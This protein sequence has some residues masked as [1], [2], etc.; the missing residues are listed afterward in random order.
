MIRIKTNAGIAQKFNIPPDEENDFAADVLLTRRQTNKIKNNPEIYRFL[1]TNLVFDFLPKGSKDTYL[2]K[3]RIIRIKISKGRYETF[4]TN[5]WN[6]E[7]SAD[8]I[9]MIYK[10]RWGIETLSVN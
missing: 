8:D 1:E 4:V 6:D 3:F 10:M 9:K 7:F 5:L 2:L